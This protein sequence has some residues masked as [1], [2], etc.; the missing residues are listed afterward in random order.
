MSQ[1]HLKRLNAPTSWP[2]LRKAGTFITR[3]YPS[4]NQKKLALPISLFFKNILKIAQTTKEVKKIL[5]TEGIL[6]DG[7]NIQKIKNSVEFMDLVHIPAQ[8]TTYRI[9]LDDHGRLTA[10]KVQ[11]KEQH[12]KICKI[13]GKQIVKGGKLQLNLNDA[14]NVL[15]DKDDYTVGDSILL[16][17]PAQK[18]QKSFKFEKGASIILI[19]GKHAGHKGQISTIEGE[20]V[21][22]THDGAAFLTLK[23]YVFVVGQEKPAITL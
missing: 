11:D 7:K 21:Q 20:A 8:K 16:E 1:K 4:R 2:I 22:Y 9:T 12:L 10:I 5:L 18:I 3:N 19:G 13:I 23:K 14:R 15:V 6:I 17:V